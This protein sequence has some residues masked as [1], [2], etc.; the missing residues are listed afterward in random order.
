[1]RKHPVVNVII[2]AALFVAIMVGAY[3]A[4]T[5]IEGGNPN[6]E[7]VLN[8]KI[9]YF[10]GTG[11]MIPVKSFHYIDGA[12]VQLNTL[13]GDVMYIGT[14]NVIIIQEDAAQ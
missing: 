14:N 7:K 3:F 6:T 4:V 2:E 5:A 12:T 8:A 11:E 10:D 13:A 1:M 9:R